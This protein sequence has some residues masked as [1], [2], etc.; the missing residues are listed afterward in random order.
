MGHFCIKLIETNLARDNGCIW[1]VKNTDMENSLLIVIHNV[2]LKILRRQFHYVFPSIMNAFAAV[3][4]NSVSCRRNPG[5][6]QANKCQCC[7]RA[8]GALFLRC[9]LVQMC[10]PRTCAHSYVVSCWSLCV[11]LSPSLPPWPVCL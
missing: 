8:F 10:A 5:R 4:A 11:S 7:L 1:T 2:R 3:S 9:V 6:S